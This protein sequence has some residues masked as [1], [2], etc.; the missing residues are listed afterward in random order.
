[1][2]FT[3]ITGEYFQILEINQSM[4]S[5]INTVTREEEFF[6]LFW[7]QEE[8][9]AS[10]NSEDYRF[11]SNTILTLTP[12][13]RFHIYHAPNLKVFRFNKSF[14][15]VDSDDQEVGCKGLLFFGGLELPVIKLDEQNRKVFSNVL[16]ILRLEMLLKDEMQMEILRMMIKRL[17][18]RSARLFKKQNQILTDDVSKVDLIREFYFLVEMHFTKIHDVGS[19]ASMLSRSPKTLSNV[20]KKVI[21]VSPSKYIQERIMMEAKNLLSY[22]NKEISEVGYEL[23]FQDVQA[24]SRFFKRNESL[25]P[26]E[27]REMKNLQRA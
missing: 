8:G 17:L 25:S 7:F 13:H 23:G 27:Y 1:M 19:Y 22:T 24:F 6:Y 16:R 20:L 11:K 10:I 18:I 12:L 26:S 9:R 4:L 14:F 15:C 21:G 2:K 5:L 3:G